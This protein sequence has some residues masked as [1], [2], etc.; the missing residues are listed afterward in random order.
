MGNKGERT[1]LELVNQNVDTWKRQAPVAF[2]R[3][4]RADRA[5]WESP[6]TP[7]WG[8]QVGGLCLAPVAVLGFLGLAHAFRR[9]G[10]GGPWVLLA[11]LGFA[12]P[13]MSVPTARRFL[14]LD[15]AWC[16]LA[17]DGFLLLLH[18]RLA[19]RLSAPLVAG[20][21]VLVLVT[22]AGWAFATVLVLNGVLTP[23]HR[24][25][26]PFGESGFGDGMTC[27]RCLQAAYEWQNEIAQQRLVV[28]F[29]TDVERED[30]TCPGGLEI[31]GRVAALSAGRPENFVEFYSVMRNVHQP[32]PWVGRY[33][34]AATTDAPTYLMQLVEAA[35][36]GTIVWHFERPTQWE[37][38]LAEQLVNA[39]GELMEFQSPLSATP[40]IQVRTEWSRRQA[41][42]RL[43]LQFRGRDQD[44]PVLE[45]T[46]RARYPFP[47][48]HIAASTGAADGTAPEWIV[49][50]WYTVA[51]RTW[52]FE[53][54]MP[55]GS[56][57]DAST[58][59]V[60]SRHGVDRVHDLTSGTKKDV[61]SVWT[62]EP[63]GLDCAIR[64]GSHWWVLDP[65]TGTLTTSDPGGA[66]VPSGRWIGITRDG[67]DHLVLASADQLIAVFDVATWTE[68]LRFPAVVSPSR[69][70]VTNECSPVVAGDGWYATFNHLRSLL[71]V[72]D[73][74][75]GEV[76][77]R[78][79]GK[80][81]GLGE[82]NNW[83]SAVAAN[84]PYLSVGYV[85]NVV[86]VKLSH[87]AECRDHRA[88]ASG[89]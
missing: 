52:S 29:D 2:R 17:A 69:R 88:A 67:A 79:L 61:Q 31:Y 34:D 51:F 74:M 72:Y 3:Y 54:G 15:L 48:L 58:F 75:G 50:S 66:R 12:V 87:L 55:I 71:T 40:A 11:I 19:R 27:F 21:A 25:L 49:G 18:S 6:S 45:T 78:D 35:R 1:A 44:C 23:R 47:V 4:F 36:P 89:R 63:H 60:L 62:R 84:G 24:Q 80:L 43:L 39:G 5:Q 10:R 73:G 22:M 20:V 30:A 38:W 81:M 14:T 42:Y 86:T 56:S 28:L 83:I 64:I 57:A 37:R 70:A 9:P 65:T 13:V 77:T 82:G 68:L 32:P 53:D 7:P 33:F 16:A 46:G 85:D 41:A 8:M 76:G 59:H 26:I